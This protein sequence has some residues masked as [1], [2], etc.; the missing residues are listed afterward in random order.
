MDD[1]NCSYSTTIE[2]TIEIDD[3]VVQ[4]INAKEICSR[5]RGP[6][7][8]PPLRLEDVRVRC[9]DSLRFVFRVIVIVGH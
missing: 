5:K 2:A 3:D 1:E 7:I 9:P 6:W 4:G 8:R